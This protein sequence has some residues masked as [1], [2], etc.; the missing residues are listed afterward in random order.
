MRVR[1]TQLC[2]AIR[3]LRAIAPSLACEGNVHRRK[4]GLVAA[5]LADL[6]DDADHLTGAFFKS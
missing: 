4:C 3:V 6:S 1:T 5:T 2:G